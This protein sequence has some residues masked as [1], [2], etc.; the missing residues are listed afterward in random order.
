M[1]VGSLRFALPQVSA[2]YALYDDMHDRN[3]N[4]SVDLQGPFYPR[5]FFE[6]FAVLLKSRARST[7]CLSAALLSRAS[8]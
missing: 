2:Q 1:R 4:V 7:Q 8:P 6:R 3:Q 5:V